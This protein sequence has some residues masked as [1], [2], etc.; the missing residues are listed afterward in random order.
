MYVC[1]CVY[2]SV[3]MYLYTFV[4]VLNLIKRCDVTFTRIHKQDRLT[5]KK[6]LL[7]LRS[8]CVISSSFELKIE[9]DVDFDQLNFRCCIMIKV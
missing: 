8:N 7:F 1:V 3:C 4:H 6:A 5:C 9:I 2:M